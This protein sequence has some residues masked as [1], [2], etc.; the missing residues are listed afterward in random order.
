MIYEKLG[1]GILFLGHTTG[2]QEQQFNVRTVFRYS[3]YYRVQISQTVKH[4]LHRSDT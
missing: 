4:V 1:Y 2:P 3:A